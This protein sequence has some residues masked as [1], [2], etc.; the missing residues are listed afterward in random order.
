M[1]KLLWPGLLF[2]LVAAVIAANVVLVVAATR[3]PPQPVDTETAP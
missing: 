1:K 2:L 3:Y